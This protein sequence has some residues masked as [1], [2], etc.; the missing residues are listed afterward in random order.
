M[1][2]VFESKAAM[3]QGAARLFQETA[4]RAVAQNGRC[5]VA[6]SGGG[7][8]ADMF[9]LLGERPYREHIPWHN[10]HIF[11]SDERL[12]PPDNDESNYKQAYDLFLSKVPIPNQNIHRTKG[13]ASP[14]KAV[15]AYKDELAHFSADGS[16]MPS[17][18]LIL[19]GMGSDGHTA[20]L[21]PGS[22]TSTERS[23][24][25]IHVTADYDGRP[26]ERISFTP[27]L[28]NKAHHILVLV[29]GE[30]KAETVTA[31]IEG[32]KNLQK[33]PIQRISPQTGTMH[34]YLDAAAAQQL[35]RSNL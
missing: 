20:S 13:E 3:S 19:L 30:K 5:L 4:V 21:F 15:Q 17:F 7:T 2:T 27:L 9:A 31:V 12:V 23:E 25:I 16:S 6:L 33:Y 28:I 1:I 34:W 24:P 35:D 26:A 11:W 18:D 32:E 22:I 10:L 29:S 8:P 14:I